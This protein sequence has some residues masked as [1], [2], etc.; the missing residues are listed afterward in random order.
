MA[1]NRTYMATREKVVREWYVVDATDKPL[2]RLA[3]QVAQVLMGKHKATYTPHVDCGD[4]VVIINAEK[5]KLTG[6]KRQNE[7]RYR[8]TGYSGGLKSQTYGEV[9]EKQPERLLEM[10]VKGM[11]PKTRLKMH[12]KLKVYAGPNHPHSAQQP[13]PLEF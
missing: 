3:S 10:V 12:K 6:N 11:L 13:K 5:V 7:K 9:L 8:H 2:G 1:S 4:F